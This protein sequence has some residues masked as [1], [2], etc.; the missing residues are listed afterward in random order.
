MDS[1]K[2]SAVIA[3]HAAWRRGER[4]GKRA[5]LRN[6]YLRGVDLRGL[7]LNEADLRD[8]DLRDANLRGANLCGA[9][10]SWADLERTKLSG[11]SLCKANL[12][13][14]NLSWADFR[15]ADLSAA[16]LSEADVRNADLR[17]AIDGEVCR[18]DFGG[19]SI[20]A[21]S[22]KTTIDCQT[23]PNSDWL[24]WS[25]ESPELTAM[26]P[27][28]PEWWRMHGEAVQAAIRCVMAMAEKN[29]GAA[30]NAK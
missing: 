21:R 6:A 20:C 14:A 5:C 18:M 22:T 27:D 10:I 4:G 13:G 9:N 7:D 30:N 15:G 2:L 8:A 19:W 17:G 12:V 11:A 1:D 28:W 25:P 26:H 29:R 3:S 23:R 24:A 16:D